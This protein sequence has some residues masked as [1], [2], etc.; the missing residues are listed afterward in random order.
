LSKASVVATLRVGRESR[1]QHADP[2]RAGEEHDRRARFIHQLYA[3]AT[4]TSDH[5][6]AQHRAVEAKIRA[7]VLRRRARFLLIGL[8]F[9]VFALACLFALAGM[10][11]WP[12]SRATMGGLVQTKPP[13]QHRLGF[14]ASRQIDRNENVL[15]Q[16]A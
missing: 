12:F 8:T 2:S 10:L 1:E 9:L 14:I 3:Q 16:R 13:A 4:A 11:S 5:L 15:Q 7:I 6:L